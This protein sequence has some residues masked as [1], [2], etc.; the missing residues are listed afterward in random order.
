M[1]YM[2]NFPSNYICET[3]AW[4]ILLLFRSEMHPVFPNI[5][6]KQGQC[7]P[8][9]ELDTRNYYVLLWKL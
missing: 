9:S 5:A 3:Q 2:R 6:V 8:F 7:L 4:V 1:Y